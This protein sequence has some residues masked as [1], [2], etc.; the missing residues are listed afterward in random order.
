M[1][2]CLQ[3]FNGAWHPK[4]L[5]N[6]QGLDDAPWAVIIL[7]AVGAV[8]SDVDFVGLA[9]GDSQDFG[10]GCCLGDGKILC[11]LAVIVANLVTGGLGIFAPGDG[12][13]ALGTVFQG[14]VWPRQVQGLEGC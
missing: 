11:G 7:A 1:T 9:F 12:Q 4:L 2:I 5:G 8:A 13:L 10:Y 3:K 14:A 6:L